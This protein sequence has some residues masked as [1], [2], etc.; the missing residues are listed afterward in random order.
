LIALFVSLVLSS[1]AV[2]FVLYFRLRKRIPGLSFFHSSTVGNL[3]A[4]YFRNRKVLGSRGLD[5]LVW[6]ALG[7]FILPSIV[8][9]LLFNRVFPEL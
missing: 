2:R 3:E 4:E 6:S 9:V 1:I 5:L 8:G 7:S